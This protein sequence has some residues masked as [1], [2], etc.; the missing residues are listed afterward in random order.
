MTRDV[1]QYKPELKQLFWSRFINWYY[2]NSKRS[3]DIKKALKESS[4]PIPLGLDK[5]ISLIFTDDG[6]QLPEFKEIVSF[7]YQQQI[8][9]KVCLFNLANLESLEEYC[10]SGPKIWQ[11]KQCPKELKYLDK[12]FRFHTDDKCYSSS[13]GNI[14]LSDDFRREF[15]SGIWPRI[16]YSLSSEFSYYP[17]G[18]YWKEAPLIVKLFYW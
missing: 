16:Y 10:P 6:L 18:I 15:Y 9:S 12:V 14:V 5:S 11:K 2:I 7:K 17:K 4:I 3:H 1:Y 8:S 13:E